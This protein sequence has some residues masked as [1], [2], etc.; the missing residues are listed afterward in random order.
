MTFNPLPGKDRIYTIWTEIIA[1]QVLYLKREKIMATHLNVNMVCT[2]DK[3]KP[4]P[5]APGI[6]YGWD[7]LQPP[8]R[9]RTH[10]GDL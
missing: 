3:I 5:E 6:S 7:Y 2:L 1:F 4:Y 9:S 8:D 10:T